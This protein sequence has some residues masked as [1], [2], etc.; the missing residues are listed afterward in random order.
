MTTSPGPLAHVRVLDLSRLYP[1]AFCT[2]LLADLGADVVKV[3]APGFGD[4]LRHMTP[5]PFKS[6]HVALNRG[7]RSL[8][9]DLKKPEAASVLR[10]LVARI[11]V[12]VESHRPG[13][14]EQLDLGYDALSAVNPGLIWCSLT[15][16]GSDGPLAHS[17]GH[18]L[19]YAGYSGL[20]G[21]L[22]DVGGTPPVP[23][24][25]LSL[26]AGAL[27]GVV[28]ILA[29]CAQRSRT[30]HGARIDTSLVEAATWMISEDVARAA[31]AP[32]PGWPAMASRAVY[33]CAD[34][35]DV[36]VA[37]SEPRTWATLC[38]ALDVPD[39]AGHRIGIDEAAAMERLAA[40][41]AT[42]PAAHWLV[43]PGLA[44]GVGPVNAPGD[45][46]AD[47]HYGDRSSIRTIEGSTTRVFVNPVRVQGV[48]GSA[49]PALSPPPELGADTDQVLAEAGFDADEIAALR[50]ADVI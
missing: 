42:R 16:F 45:L 32:A 20:L 35:R 49:Q 34:D 1:G 15:G 10:R 24:C 28:G 30:G 47:P 9:L 25:T 43:T 22:A 6:G 18:D 2:S 12:I 31:S 14:L 37:S 50:A 40:V 4:G 23:Q 21:L 8:S 38:A 19:T 33:R 41:F 26:P 11:D 48:D 13:S 39:L 3:E 7:K 46:L 5:E 29:A 27:M 36:T 17:P 44:G